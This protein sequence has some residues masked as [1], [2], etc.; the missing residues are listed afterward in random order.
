MPRLRRFPPVLVPAGLCLLAL[1]ACVPTADVAPAADATDPA[2]APMM[3]ALP[4][5]VADQPLRRTNSQATA[6][7]GNPSR[8]ILRCGVVPP[9]PTTDACVGVN[10][11]DWVVKQ[12]D[13]AWTLTTYGRSPATEVL[14]DPDAIASSTVLVDLA[15]AV[16]RVPATRHCTDPTTV[17][18]LPGS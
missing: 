15:N 6:A 5:T 9:G 10:G 11:V 16:S 17:L 13:V 4:Q 3:I 1:T 12:G 2:C 8:L 18:E 14:F 7:W